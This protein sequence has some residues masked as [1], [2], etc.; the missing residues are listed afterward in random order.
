MREKFLLPKRENSVRKRK[1]YPRN[2]QNTGNGQQYQV[3][4]VEAEK[5]PEAGTIPFR[6]RKNPQPNNNDS[7][8][9]EASLTA[10][11]LVRIAIRRVDK[12]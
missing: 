10:V 7:N 8:C 2:E 1:K 9:L 5:I 6:N 3:E 4:Q 11:P 12:T